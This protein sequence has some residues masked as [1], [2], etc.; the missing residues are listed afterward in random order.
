MSE[1]VDQTILQI[2]RALKIL[3][4]NEDGRRAMRHLHA[5]IKFAETGLTQEAKVAA[6][7][8]FT[9]AIGKHPLTVRKALRL[10]LE[11]EPSCNTPASPAEKPPTSAPEK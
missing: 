9:Y 10:E 1:R 7:T 11:K 6:A 2:Q 4:A 3:N 8:L 5:L